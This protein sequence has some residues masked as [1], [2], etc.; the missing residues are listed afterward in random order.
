MNQTN[1]TNRRRP[2]TQPP[3]IPELPQPAAEPPVRRWPNPPARRGAPETLGAE[4]HTLTCLMTAQ[5]QLLGEI[6]DLLA[7]QADR[8]G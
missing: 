6:R 7:R 3:Q 4:L 2:D 1:G 8:N 5:N